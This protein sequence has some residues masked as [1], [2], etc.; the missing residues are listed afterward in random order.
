M[1]KQVLWCYYVNTSELPPV[2]LTNSTKT[3]HFVL[4][5]PSHYDDEGYVIQWMRSSI[6]SNTMAAI[7]GLALDSAERKILGDDVQMTVT[8]MDETNTRVNTRELARMI[9]EAGGLGL[10]AMVG[11]QTNQFPRAMDL[12]REFC[13]SE[14][15]VC[16]GGF[17]VSGCLAMLPDIP[18]DL[19]EAM[20]EGISLFA[21]EVEGHLDMLL[22][23]G[24]SKQLK[25]LY[26]VMKD[27]PG[28]EGQPV[29][30]LPAHLIHRMSGART[31]F[32]AGRGCPFLCS[33]CTIIN[34]QGRKSRYRT[35]DD[36]EQLVR[37][38]VAQGIHK[39]F[40]TDD[41]FA[42]NKAWESILDRL[43][44]LREEE[45]IQ[46][47][48]TI[49]VDT[50]CHKIPRFIEKAGRAG[51]DRVFIGLESINPESLDGSRKHQNNI[52]EYRSM[53]QAWHQ[54]GALTLAGLILGFPSDTP[55]SILRDIRIIQH[56]LP[57]DL[58]YFFILTPLPGSQ[59][60]K[61]LYEQGVAL[62]LDMNA[63]DSV[64]V[65]MPHAHMSKQE[66]ME[67]YHQA[68]E[69]YYTP[70]HVERV[71]R[72]AKEWQ[73][74]M[75]KVKWMMLSFYC[76]DKVEGVHPMD[77]GIFRLKYRRDRRVGLPREH[78]VI[79]YAR[80]GWE[81]LYK[82]IRFLWIYLI[83]HR[84]YRHVVNGLIQEEDDVAMQP[85]QMNELDTLEI[86][87]ATP[88][89]KIVVEKIKNKTT[90]SSST[91]PTA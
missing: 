78:P 45:D 17:H 83:F 26:N 51:V 16:I 46:C 52:T 18:T 88:A 77:S 33:F 12:A 19:Q 6:P 34:V 62:E 76:A 70:E 2:K 4:I 84:A 79:F 72:R 81:I 54:V 68:W 49:Q 23:D 42:R 58:L 63:Y 66:L 80:Y 11:V 59:D 10:I 36:I 20:D 89:A 25:P 87:T 74:S 91:V 57:I 41:N 30:Y 69:A 71:I 44:Q 35:P 65:T 82:H 24:Y 73:F 48:I 37:M 90:K 64:H 5:K 9:Q 61:E 3:F 8:A 32:D 28:L 67:V 1:A 56:E 31:S 14:I 7:Y 55:E 85:V 13:R 15:Q 39:F 21:G 43:I 47:K 29:P 60:H 22:R 27:P 86:Y 50:M 40:V 38:N 53:L 75:N